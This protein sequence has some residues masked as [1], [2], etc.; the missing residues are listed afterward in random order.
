[1]SD[2]QMDTLHIMIQKMC[3]FVTDNEEDSGVFEPKRGSVL[4]RG[5]SR[6]K[7]VNNLATKSKL[8]RTISE[9]QL[10]DDNSN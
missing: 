9:T 6:V 8:A 3:K 4:E 7:S 5:L 2:D 1:M 10:Y